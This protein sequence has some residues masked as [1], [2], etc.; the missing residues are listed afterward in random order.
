MHDDRE[1]I[2]PFHNPLREAVNR[3]RASDE[4]GVCRCPI[5]NG[6]MQ[7]RVDCRGPRFVC[8]CDNQGREAA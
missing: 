4:L 1:V 2:L 5:C 8:A 3:E 6:P 7:M